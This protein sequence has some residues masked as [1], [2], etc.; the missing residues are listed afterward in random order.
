MFEAQLA[1]PV[2]RPACS[3]AEDFLDENGGIYKFLVAA[4]RINGFRR[5]VAVVQFIAFGINHSA[6]AHHLQDAAIIRRLADISV[7]VLPI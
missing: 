1:L 3:L 7:L 2:L 4:V 5:G 6:G